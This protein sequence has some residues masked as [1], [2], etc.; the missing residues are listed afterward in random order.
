MINE[1]IYTI[2]I[3]FDLKQ[4][5]YYSTLKILE[6]LCKKYSAKQTYT[7]IDPDIHNR[8]KTCIFTAYFDQTDIYSFVVLIR[9]IKILS[10]VYIESISK[11]DCQLLYASKSY[12]KHHNNE[13]KEIIKGKIKTNITGIYDDDESILIKEIHNIHK[14]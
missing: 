13:M 4:C 3:V 8:K 11:N 10:K 14:K 9:E 7:M 6:Q 12:F 2:E 5:E 1:T